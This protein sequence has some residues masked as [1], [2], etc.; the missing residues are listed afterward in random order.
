[1]KRDND[2]SFVL[3]R[4]FISLGIVLLLVFITSAGD[5]EIRSGDLT[6]DG[7][8]T[9]KP[10]PQPTVF[11]EGTLYY[12]ETE[13]GYKYY[14]GS[15]WKDLGYTFEFPPGAVVTYRME[16]SSYRSVNPDMVDSWNPEGYEYFGK[17]VSYNCPE[18]Y[19]VVN[20]DCGY[21]NAVIGTVDSC[22]AWGCSGGSEIHLYDANSCSC[23]STGTNKATLTAYAVQHK[24]VRTNYDPFQYYTLVTYCYPHF[25]PHDMWPHLGTIYDCFLVNFDEPQC[26]MEFQCG[27]VIDVS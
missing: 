18:G 26:W 25:V 4:V 2:R 27:G 14:D 7:S 24:S 5:V 9:V 12:D 10:S 22:G 16:A 20:I 8:L 3:N 19:S 15:E 21:T 23:S 17:S 13:K 6:L 11:E 1:M